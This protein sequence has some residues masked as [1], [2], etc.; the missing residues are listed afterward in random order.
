MK[1]IV[2]L[3]DGWA[4][5]PDEN[6]QTPLSLAN[7]PNIDKIA[8][9]SACGLTKTVPDGMKPGS[10]V[11]NMAVMG[12]DPA[13]YYTGR[14]P[15]EAASMGIDLGADDV[16]YRCNLVT[17]GGDGQY[18]S[19][20]MKDYSA[21]EI[22][23]TSAEKLIAEINAA[24]IVP[25]GCELYAGV[26]YR[27]CL[28][29]RGGKTGAVLTPPHDISGKPVETYL[30][31]GLYADELLTFQ[32]R[33]RDVLSKSDINA[34]RIAEGK[35]PATSCWLWGEGTRP[36][37]TSFEKLYGLKG[38]VISAVDLVK[39][40]GI[41]AGMDSIDV[42]G[43]CGTI[44]T[45]F[46]GKA[47]AAL[48]AIKT[49]DYVYI[50][51]EAPDECGHQG[52][53]EGKIRSIELIDSLVVRPIFEEMTRRG[54]RF[55]LLITPDHPT[56]L[57]LRTHVS[58]PVPFIMYD[59]GKTVHGIETYNEGLVRTTRLYYPSGVDMFT[60]FLKVD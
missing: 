11:A 26:S 39:G 15:L 40:L 5:Y 19:L 14:S 30:P 1:Y 6:G 41:V 8:Q 54:E 35:N 22:D 31:D 59:S 49:H 18:S 38:A 3:G 45:N 25:E 48:E 4:D 47:A 44:N 28:V 21:G 10:D 20:Y 60:A 34:H 43:A 56:P 42:E 51:M 17:L 46:A 36:S 29:R 2:I 32:Q 53:K 55:K 50:H 16:T 33:S 13:K 37:F 12:Y 52:D 7:K 24:G 9:M 23:T 27:H 57:A 58:D